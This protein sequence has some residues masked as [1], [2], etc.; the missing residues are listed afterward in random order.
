MAHRKIKIM[1]V[2]SRR[3]FIFG[4]HFVRPVFYFTYKSRGYANMQL[5]LIKNPDET[6]GLAYKIARV[7]Y[8]ETQ[9]ASLRVVEALTSMIQNRVFAFGHT[10]EQIV[11][12]AQL[13]DVLNKSSPRHHLMQV[14]PDNRGFQ[15]CLRVATRMMRGGLGDC[16]WG[17]TCFHRDGIVPGW[18]TSRG[19][20]ADI[21][22]LLFYL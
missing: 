20:I 1:S 6:K 22:G 9:A 11:S 15:M 10:P 2:A 13:F 21:D 17:A 14:T 18:A 5:T 7:V 3:F 8:A 19:Y 4:S 16:C 12:D